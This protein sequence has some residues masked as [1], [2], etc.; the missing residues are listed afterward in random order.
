M[1]PS[2]I[3]EEQLGELLLPSYRSYE[4][5]C[6]PHTESYNK[7]IQHLKSGSGTSSSDCRY[8]VWISFSGLGNRILTLA[9]AFVYALLTD[10]VLLLDI[11][12][13][14]QDLFCEPFPEASWLLPPDFPCNTTS[15]KA[16]PQLAPE[17]RE[18]APDQLHRVTALHLS[19]PRPR[20]RLPRPTVLLRSRSSTSAQDTM[21]DNQVQQLLRPLPFLDALFRAG[22]PRPLPGQGNRLPLGGAVSL[23]PHKRSV[24]ARNQILPSLSSQG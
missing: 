10:R 24:G 6:G 16:Q 14:M 4:P 3:V 17:L 2:G 8:L 19:P 13:H 9:S 22:A 23:P 1:S 15:L 20:L 7:T 18:P 12:G 11:Q 5:R 21:V